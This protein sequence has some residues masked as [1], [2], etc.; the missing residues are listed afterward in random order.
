MH[1]VHRK[2]V[3]LH[4]QMQCLDFFRFLTTPYFT[5]HR[6]SLLTGYQV[7]GRACLTQ[8]SVTKGTRSF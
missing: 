7:P 1:P 5:L 8:L 2:A 4:N 3:S 6:G